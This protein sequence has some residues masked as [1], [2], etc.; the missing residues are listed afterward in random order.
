VPGAVILD[1]GNL[2]LDSLEG[3]EDI[4]GIE[5]VTRLY[6]HNNTIKTLRA[7]DFAAAVNLQ[8]IGLSGNGLK[9]IEPN[10]FAG[11]KKLKV[12][13]LS[14][15]NIERI[16]E[17]GLNG[18][19]T[20]RFLG[21]S[22]NPMP[23]PKK[24]LQPQ[25]PKAFIT[26]SPITKAN[27]VKWTAGLAT[28][29]VALLGTIITV[30][31]V[32]SAYSDYK[33][34]LL[35]ASGH[36]RFGSDTQLG[37]AVLDSNLEEVERLLAEGAGVDTPSQTWTPLAFAAGSNNEIAKALLTAGADPNKALLKVRD[38]EAAT[39]LLDHGATIDD[40]Q[41]QHALGEFGSNKLALFLEKGAD[42][43]GQSVADLVSGLREAMAKKNKAVQDALIEEL[44]RREAINFSD[45]YTT[46]LS[47]AI[48]RYS[49]D[50]NESVS[51]LDKLLKAGANPNIPSKVAERVGK[52]VEM[53][54][55]EQAKDPEV[56][57]ILLDNGAFITDKVIEKA[58]E[59]GE[60]GKLQ[61]LL[62][63]GVQVPNELI[64][65][66]F[67]NRE[68]DVLEILLEKGVDINLAQQDENTLE[69]ILNKRRYESLR[70]P[71]LNRAAQEQKVKTEQ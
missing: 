18:M 4:P 60:L 59:N 41:V 32:R 17:E 63:R 42:M 7:G 35:D 45:G 57:K 53:T 46:L 6:L 71:K 1:L 34:E 62:A 64:E 14:N 20:L 38:K 26:T 54:P 13:D 61:L 66:A 49:K 19:P 15:N 52:I 21:M 39:F 9:D 11:L 37:A 2:A 5:K 33:K 3:L 51:R 58:F 40:E 16:P 50:D 70:T 55:L 43:D 24:E 29:V 10:A 23:N 31:K 25:V 44:S 67:K 65:K 30:K 36:G 69:A 48:S 22:N 12:L 68:F 28:V 56:A 8:L 47:F 27:I